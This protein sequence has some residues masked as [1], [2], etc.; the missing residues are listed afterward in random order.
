MKCSQARS[1]IAL[2]VGDDLSE[3]EDHALRRH[4][5]MC[6]PCRT[7]MQ[8]ARQSYR[9]LRTHV[10]ASGRPDESLWPL[11]ASR[12]SVQR[13]SVR[14]ERFNGWVPALAVAAA[15]LVMVVLSMQRS[16]QPAAPESRPIA[17]MPVLSHSA[18]PPGSEPPLIVTPVEWDHRPDRRR[19]A[20]PLILDPFGSG[21]DDWQRGVL[22]DE[23][24][25]YFYRVRMPE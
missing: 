2:R 14:A 3:T 5:A 25:M 12:I 7:H 1:A 4:L 8:D 24:Q 11:I 20:H 19:P 9:A 21:V 17:T 15:V 6:P 13:R 23:S 22:D 18:D 10:P 16:T